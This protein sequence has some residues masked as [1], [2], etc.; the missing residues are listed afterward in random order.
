MGTA[1]SV[2]VVCGGGRIRDEVRSAADG[3]TVIAADGG[4]DEAVR[5]E[6]FVDVLVGDMDSVTPEALRQV[7]VG[8]G[9]IRRHPRDKDATDLELALEE[10]LELEPARILV[11]GGGGGRFDFLIGNALALAHSRLA[12]VD[13][14]AWFGDATVHVVRDERRLSGDPGER[15]SLLAVGGA[16]RGVRTEGLRWPL[17]GD[18]LP[19]G[20]GLGMSN[21][22]AA[23]TAVVGIRDGVLL[24]IRPGEGAP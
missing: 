17:D 7:E 4:A 23:E 11:A 1:P 3:R 13:V 18:D 21:E 20:V 12:A 15:I 14:D 10:A 8:G 19:A 6:L 5:L 22:F 24:A 2:L 16:A 9:A